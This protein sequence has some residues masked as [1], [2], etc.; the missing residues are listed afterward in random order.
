MRRRPHAF[1]V[2]LKSSSVGSR[3]SVSAPF[4]AHLLGWMFGYRINHKGSEARAA[5][6]HIYYTQLC[7]GL[8]MGIGSF[9]FP[10][11]VRL[12]MS[13]NAP[14][15]ARKGVSRSR[16][17]L[18]VKQL[19]YLYTI[20]SFSFS[21]CV[22][23]KIAI[24]DCPTEHLLP[25]SLSQVNIRINV[26]LFRGC[27]DGSKCPREWVSCGSPGVASVACGGRA[28]AHAEPGRTMFV[29]V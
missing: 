21:L 16:K 18:R 10:N 4:S 28:P 22:L 23:F 13:L 3:N 19:V 11:P 5:T 27:F 2:P 8:F 7:A 29:G 17:L 14:F 9:R 26:L 6:T 24:K 15:P 25:S 12:L 1:D 20:S